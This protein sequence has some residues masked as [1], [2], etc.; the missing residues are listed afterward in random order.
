MRA[1]V[2][3]VTVPVAPSAPAGPDD[4]YLAFDVF[5]EWG[6]HAIVTTRAAGSF[7][8]VGDAPIG[9]V[10]DRWGTL[11]RYAAGGENGRLA[12]AR[13][14]HGADLLEHDGTWRGWLRGPAADGHVAIARGTTLTVTVADCVPVYLAHPSGATAMLHSGWRGTAAGIVTAAIARLAT[15]GHRA[16]ELRVL[17]GPAI[18]GACYEVSPDVYAA[19]TGTRVDRPRPVALDAVIARQARQAGVREVYTTDLCTRCDN[20]RLFSHRAGDPGRQL[21]VLWAG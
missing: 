15:A 17:T 3:A 2:A 9:A 12:T 21:G 4:A 11:Q 16:S 13:Q 7:A 8:S 1:D 14:V 10:L 20:R 19:L 5:A 18:C 6:I